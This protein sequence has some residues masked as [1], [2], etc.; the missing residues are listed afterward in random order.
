MPQCGA[1]MATVV[2]SNDDGES[3]DHLQ[4]AGDLVCRALDHGE[5]ARE[6]LTTIESNPTTLIH[7]RAS[8][9]RHALRGHI[10]TGAGG[11]KRNRRQ[12]CWCRRFLLFQATA[13]A[14]PDC[15]FCHC[16]KRVRMKPIIRLVELMVLAAG[17]ASATAAHADQTNFE[18]SEA[19]ATGGANTVEFPSKSFAFGAFGTLGES[20]SSERLGDYVL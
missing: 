17:I 1:F 6:I 10:K 13:H 14:R 3:I 8:R 15:A 20:H 2:P 18:E 9:R 12:I 16:Q 5:N 7:R 4:D 19:P 11:A